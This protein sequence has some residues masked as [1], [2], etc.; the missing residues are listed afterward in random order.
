A[1]TA[2]A[3]LITVAIALGWGIRKPGQA[4]EARGQT[5]APPPPIKEESY[6]ESLRK[7]TQVEPDKPVV[8]SLN[9]SKKSEPDDIPGENTPSG[10]QT[11]RPKSFAPPVYQP[12]PEQLAQLEKQFPTRGP[13][14]AET[15]TRQQ[16]ARPPVSQGPP[17]PMTGPDAKSAKIPPPQTA[18][19][20]EPPP[21]PLIPPTRPPPLP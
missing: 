1:G 10:T 15:S 4:G 7:A 17:Q 2:V 11:G 3:V 21:T 20:T 5:G 8:S 6:V 9:P 12:P 16:S 18:P 14:Q 19:N 13:I